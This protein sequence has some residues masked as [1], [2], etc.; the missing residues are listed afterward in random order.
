MSQGTLKNYNA[1][2]FSLNYLP[3]LG[4][5][6]AKAFTILVLSVNNILQQKNIYGFQFS[7]DGLRSKAVLPSASTFVFIGAFIN[8]GIDRTQDVINSN[9]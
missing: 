7:K 8:F 3:N 2:N 4:K 5:K 6:E 1:L 9:L